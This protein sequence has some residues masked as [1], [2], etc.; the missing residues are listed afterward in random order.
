MATGDFTRATTI[1]S[2]DSLYVMSE[3]EK[4]FIWKQRSNLRS[5]PEALPKIVLSTPWTD[6]RA[7]KELHRILKEWILLS[8]FHLLVLCVLFK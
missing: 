6:P 4:Q 8:L 2:K 5:V 3:E 1:V 7:V